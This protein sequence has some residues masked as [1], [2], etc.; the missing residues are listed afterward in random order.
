MEK[1]Y[2]LWNISLQGWMS[3]GS[4]NSDIAYAKKFAETEAFELARSHFQAHKAVHLIPLS[5][6]DLERIKS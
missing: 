5:F 6:E 3:H 1:F 4:Y 2:Y